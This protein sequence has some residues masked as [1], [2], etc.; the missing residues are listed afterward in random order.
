MRT[1]R[2][3]TV[4]G[5]LWNSGALMLGTML[6]F[7]T[8][9]ILARLLSPHE[10]GLIG[11]ILVITGFA[12]SI[13]DIGLGA[14][15]VQ[16]Q[17]LS[18]VNLD[19][20]FWLNVATGGVLTLVFSLSAPLI[21]RF[22]GE[23]L[24]RPLMVVVAFNFIIGSLNVVQYSLLQKALDFQRRFWIDT[25][26]IAISG[27]FALVLALAGA[28]VW[29]LVGQSVCENVIRTTQIWRLSSWRPRRTFDPAAIKELLTFGWHLVG[30][31]VVVY[32]A[33][34][35][36]QLA[37][38]RQIGSSALGIYNLSDRLMRLPLT[39]ATDVSGAV[40]FPA[41]S[42]AQNDI[43]L[44]RRAYLRA[45]RMIALFTFPMMLGF[46][47][48][49][50]SMVLVIYGN[51]WQDAVVIVQLL[52]FAGLA[53]SVYNTAGWIFLSR[54]RTDILFRL[55]VL[56]MLVRVAG[57]LI[58]MHWAM[59]GVAWAYVLGGYAFLLYPTWSL[60][61][62]LIGLRFAGLMKNVAAPFACA[63]CMAA[64]V[65]ISYHSVLVHQAQWLRL[66]INM[67]IGIVVYCFLIMHF[68]IAAWP[69]IR[70]LILE[71]GV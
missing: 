14:S 39:T 34:N 56:T 46:S 40:M 22:Y 57:V 63:A 13:A 31:N 52:C 26:A 66:V 6:R 48:L 45:T 12:S 10:F 49:A 21:A 69:D 42:E 62:G 3:R 33:Q 47:V 61:G 36:A 70:E 60:A 71:T 27:F 41:L 15:I 18:K 43:E 58:G 29:S 24:L 59:L 55:G 23:P 30:F 67:L 11:M 53:Q 2:Q 38:G 44:A 1:L 37:I 50:E 64:I 25:V 28:G 8:T 4:A 19:S 20:V 68:R 32:C 51:R 9:V 5:L 17:E 35:F 54:G 7:A 16:K 65:W